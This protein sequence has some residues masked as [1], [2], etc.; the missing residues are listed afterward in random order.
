MRQ[1]KT[2][3]L[4]LGGSVSSVG[5]VVTAGSGSCPDMAD[6]SSTTAATSTQTTANPASSG[7]ALFCFLRRGLLLFLTGVVLIDTSGT[8]SN[9]SFANS[10]V[11]ALTPSKREAWLLPYISPINPNL[12]Y[13]IPHN[14]TI[15]NPLIF[16][17]V[18]GRVFV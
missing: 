18:L 17:L 5:A 12:I 4:T 2:Q 6:S 15:A 3:S 13:I 10:S 8:W 16:P 1:E 7:M 9:F 11:N 14:S